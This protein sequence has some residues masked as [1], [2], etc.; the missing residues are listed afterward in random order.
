MGKDSYRIC[1]KKGYPSR[2]E[3][4]RLCRQ[5]IEDFD[6]LRTYE[7]SKNHVLVLS[8]KSLVKF[9][10]AANNHLVDLLEQ[11]RCRSRCSG[12]DRLPALLLL[13]Y[14]LQSRDISAFEEIR[15]PAWVISESRLSNGFAQA[16]NVEALKKQVNALIRR[17]HIEHPG[18][19]GNR[20]RI[21]W[22]PD[23]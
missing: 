4:K 13:Q 1:I 10:P 23:R 20:N 15:P 3:F 21:S 18:F 9:L 16:C 7:I 19:D 11:R 14:K 8:V 2:R 17:L 12:S 22:K 5:I 6:T